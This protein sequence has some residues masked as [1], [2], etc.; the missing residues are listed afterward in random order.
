MIPGSVTPLL[1]KSAAAAGG[2]Q[3][4]RSLRFNSSDSAYLSKVFAVAGNRKT[5]TWSAWVKR[6]SL[7]TGDH[8]FL[9]S[10]GTTNRF[11]LFISSANNIEIHGNGNIWRVT[12]PVYRDS[13]AWFHLTCVL[14]TPDGTTQNR[15]RL[16]INGVEVTTWSTNVSIT[17]NDD[18]DINNTITHEIGRNPD[19]SNRFFNG[20]LT[21]IHFIDGQALTPSS[22]TETDATTGQLIP[23]TY[24]G[25]YGTNG[26]NLLF[27][28]NSAATAS[29]LGK[30]YSGLG[31][32]WTPNNFSVTAG[33]G[34][35][36]LVDSP[37][38]Y[39]TDTG[40]GGTVRGNYAT[41]NPLNAGPSTTLSNGNLFFTFTSASSRLCTSTIGM[42][43]GKW[44]WEGT[45]ATGDFSGTSGLG[46]AKPPINLSDS[47][48]QSNVYAYHANGQKFVNGDHGSSFGATYTTSDIIGIAFN[49]DTGELF[50]YK[51]GTLQGTIATGL[52][53]GPYFSVVNSYS[54][55]SWD[56][57]Y[58]QR[59]FAYTAPSGYKGLCTQNLPAP[60]VTKSNE[61]FDVVT[62]NGSASPIAIT[63]P[64]GF[65]PD[66]VWLKC[67]SNT[68][69]QWLT[70]T[71]RGTNKQLTSN[72]TIAEE[73]R[74]DRISSFDASGFTV[75]NH[76][77]NSS[78]Q[79][80]VGWAWKGIGNPSTSSTT[81]NANA[82]SAG[83]PSITSQVRANP[84][85]GFSVVTYT[86][87]GANATVGHGLGVAPAM[88]I[89]KRRST[90]DDWA[91]Y[92]SAIG[93][94]KFLYLNLTSAQD[95][96]STRWQD[97]TPSSTIFSIGSSGQ[98]NGSGSTY[99]AY[100]FAPVVGYS[101]F[102]SYTG[103][104]STD[105]PFVYTGFRPRWL[106]VKNATNGS[107]WVLHDTARSTY[108]VSG[109]ELL[110]DS[111]GAEYT[112]TRFD[113]LSNGF[114]GRTTNN[115]S[116]TSSDTYIY[117]AFAEAPLNYSRAR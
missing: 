53:V 104:G 7:A 46:I 78:G 86:G 95:T 109:Q 81:I 34:N 35:D 98:V 15:T 31:N 45:F 68:N 65:S 12:T 9:F 51:N 56:I 85:A 72:D 22:F 55:S 97:T 5:W 47:V 30:D 21:N 79:T 63:L 13:S 83:V 48:D 10:A 38:N 116:N 112:F 80:F 70:D 8:Q 61:V 73:S 37:T 64:G 71:I 36:S 87:T 84:T 92:H 67:R 82:Y 60:L 39:G 93:A 1:L 26:F 41:L 106:L 50:G 69:Y 91:V 16:Y 102:G 52:T 62:Y 4:E 74:T 24:T 19:G 111:S 57:N 115:A 107:S 25:S 11:A 29:T 33:A 6:A 101:S 2:L 42:S 100:C 108:N 20:Y 88:M 27:A 40:V 32:N 75:A 99:V 76:D 103:N 28:D 14:N 66:L 105:G 58:G 77:V 49:A 94:T 3:I 90:A 18:F 110:P 17:Q 23:K 113:I 44:Y 59:A 43:S 96:A 89:V 117:A 114:K 54:N